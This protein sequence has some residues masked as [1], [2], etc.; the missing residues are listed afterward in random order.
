MGSPFMTLRESLFRELQIDRGKPLRFR[1]GELAVV[2]PAAQVTS[3][4]GAPRS[5]GGELKVEAMLPAGIL[6]KYLVVMDYEKCTLTLAPPGTVKAQGIAVPFR[7]NAETGLISVE[8]SIDGEPFAITIDNGSAYTWVRQSAAQ[9]WLAAHPGWERGVGAVGTS[10]MMMSGEGWETA[11][12]LLRIPE[13]HLG[14]LTLKDVGVLAAGP[15]RNVSGDLDLFDWYSRKNAGRVIG[16]I[17]GNVLKLFRLTIDYSNR[18]TYWQTQGA[19]EAHDLDYVGLTLRSAHGEFFVAGVAT[20]NGQPT[21]EGVLPGDKLIRIGELP[22]ANA[23]WGAIYGALHGKPGETRM[24]LVE[25][26]GKQ[27]TVA[28]AVTAF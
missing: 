19:P 14:S 8:A 9:G 25:R 3:E 15:G 6:Q 5:M 12:I 26:G 22:A 4:P 27:I 13:V 1:A 28:A 11:G 10:N 23:T 21:V 16:W 2:V 7:I 20:K 24:L 18:I 17:G